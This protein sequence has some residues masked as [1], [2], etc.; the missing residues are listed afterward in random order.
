M[1]KMKKSI[2]FMIILMLLILT[3]CQ[4]STTPVPT[5]I[6]QPTQT[7]YIITATPLPVTDTPTS[8]P[9]PTETPTATPTATPAVV[10]NN[11]DVKYSAGVYLDDR[12][13]PATLIY[14][15]A[16]ALNRYEY[17][18]AYSYWS[19]PS[20]SLG[21]LDEF[22]AQFTGVSS[23][24]VL[25]GNIYSEGA[26]GSIYSTAPVLFKFTKTDNSTARSAACFIMRFPQPGNYGEPPITPLHVES[27]TLVAVEDSASDADA[28]GNACSSSDYVSL[29]A[30]STADSL[31]LED[32]TNLSASN[33]IDNRSGA[34]EVISS[35]FN[36]LNRKEYVRAYSYWENPAKA[37]GPFDKYSKGFSDTGE[38]KAIFG[39]VIVDAAAG[40][41]VYK[42][43][44]A[45]LVTTTNG[46]LQTFVGC[47]ALHVA[48][49]GMQATLPFKPI[50]ITKGQFK[51]YP[52]G[53]DVNLLLT[54][55]C[56]KY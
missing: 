26:A 20:D 34:G 43:P 39:I 30:G 28:L 13:T 14:S 21:T 8:T 10:V 48:N 15:I 18:R 33:Y 32:Q 52:N 45:Q 25:L 7:P 44:V 31:E 42:V 56:D 12:S 35:L 3:G 16:N 19:S 37:V 24:Q 23:V 51:S 41:W 55:A 9:L 47:Y 2:T 38:I 5:Q 27:G 22:T 6:P 4:F 46:S 40:Q 29:A 36:A 53:T 54:H 17:L 1:V 50:G 49:P 11:P